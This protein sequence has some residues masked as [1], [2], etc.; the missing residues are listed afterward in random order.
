MLKLL[1]PL[2]LP[3]ISQAVNLTIVNTGLNL[4]QMAEGINRTAIASSLDPNEM[5]WGLVH[6]NLEEFLEGISFT[7]ITQAIQPREILA[8]VSPSKVL[9]GVQPKELAAGLNL[10]G[11]IPAAYDQIPTAVV[12][13]RETLWIYPILIFT[14]ILSSVFFR[15]LSDY[16]G[17]RWIFL[18]GNMLSFIAFIATG[19]ANGGATITGLVS[20]TNWTCKLSIA[21][22]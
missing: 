9:P 18:F 14:Q 1:A 7:S 3:Q 19:F 15:R 16:V 5:F 20:Q 2:N 11:F 21:N 6:T 4:T 13:V 10:T 12:Q 17:R 22:T 8:G